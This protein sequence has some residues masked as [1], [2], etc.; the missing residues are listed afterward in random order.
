MTIQELLNQSLEVKK[1][2]LEEKYIQTIQQIGDIV[3]SAL[4]SGNK[5]LIA[6]NGGSAAD[7]QHFV[8][9]L[10]GKFVEKRK[11]LAAIALTTNASI[12]TA[13]GNDFGF[14]E[15]FSKQIEALGNPGDVF[16]GISTSSYSQNKLGHSQNMIKA[17]RQAK[18]RGLVRV[19]LLG[20]DGGM[21]K[22]LCD[23][24]LIIPSQ[25][26][27]NIQEAHTMIIHAVCYLIDK[28]FSNE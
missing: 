8:A 5:I 14:E 16:I 10:A 15:V 4:K 3:V 17:M 27:Q 6:G 28:A 9:E 22:G 11:G 23:I 19:G 20:K 1:K 7:A 26:T 25:D 2:L 18:T 24:S 12:I 13:I 21:I